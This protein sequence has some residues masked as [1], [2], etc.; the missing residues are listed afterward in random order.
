AGLRAALP[1]EPVA[2]LAFRDLVLEHVG[3]VDDGHVGLWVFDPRRRWRGTTGHQPAYA[4]VEARFA[5]EEAGDRDARGRRVSQCDGA[6]PDDVLRPVPGE[7]LPALDYVPIVLSREPRESIE[8][9]FEG[10]ETERFALS[11]VGI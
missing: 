8:C 9:A 6:R 11:R 1:A 2:P 4:A 3:F 5:R 7:A 10:G